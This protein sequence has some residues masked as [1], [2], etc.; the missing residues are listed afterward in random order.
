MKKVLSKYL[1]LLSLLPILSVLLL[2][3]LEAAARQPYVICL[4]IFGNSPELELKGNETG[5]VATLL[6]NA[7]STQWQFKRP[8]ER[9]S[10][11]WS[12]FYDPTFNEGRAQAA[13]YGFE[14]GFYVSQL[15]D[16]L[17]VQIPESTRLF[18]ARNQAHFNAMAYSFE[19]N[20]IRFDF[21]LSNKNEHR[22]N[23]HYFA[24]S[25]T[26]RGIEVSLSDAVDTK[27]RDGSRYFRPNKLWYVLSA[28]KNLIPFVKQE[29]LDF[30]GKNLGRFI[31]QYNDVR[32][33]FIF[34][35]DRGWNFL[36][37]W[38]TPFQY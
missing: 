12:Q 21:S 22:D 13:G 3:P 2:K 30:E 36:G 15:F 5:I 29:F 33:L 34:L 11:Y 24:F 6:D 16:L 17:P 31:I 20:K 8:A 1:A 19:S 7:I 28:N 18:F 32:N 23:S 10:L 26:P 35:R 38:H 9:D 25:L 14:N 4:N 27:L 37:H